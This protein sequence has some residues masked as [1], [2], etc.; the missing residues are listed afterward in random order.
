[1]GQHLVPRSCHTETQAGQVL[2]SGGLNTKR[3]NK[4]MFLQLYPLHKVTG[5]SQNW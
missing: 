2:G 4:Q 5:D 3:M 1:M